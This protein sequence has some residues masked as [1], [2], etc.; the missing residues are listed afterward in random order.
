[1]CDHFNIRCFKVRDPPY[2]QQTITSNLPKNSPAVDNSHKSTQ[3]TE[4]L[5]SKRSI[6]N[7]NG[8][9]QNKSS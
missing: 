9:I 5:L 6:N 2:M 3:L 8:Q 1:M 7:K 4:S